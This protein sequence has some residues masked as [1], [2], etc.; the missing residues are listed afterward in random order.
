MKTSKA[1]IKAANIYPRLRLFT[2]TPKGLKSTGIHKVKLILDKLISDNVDVCIGER[3][4]HEEKRTMRGI[5]AALLKRHMRFIANKI[6]GSDI[7]DWNTGFFA[8]NQKGIKTLA[9]FDYARYP[10]TELYLRAY[11]TRLSMSSIT[12]KQTIR[13]HGKSTLNI[14]QSTRLT[15]RFYLIMIRQLMEKKYKC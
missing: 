9:Q 14:Y 2:K 5:S 11:Q 10:E 8:L 15:V 12:I 6:T 3:I 4:N 7:K 1:I 13:T